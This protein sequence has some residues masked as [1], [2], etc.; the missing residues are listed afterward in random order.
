[1]N[2]TNTKTKPTTLDHYQ[3]IEICAAAIRDINT[4]TIAPI[5]KQIESSI[6]SLWP[7]MAN[8]TED[9]A[10]DWT[11]DILGCQNAE[12]VVK[13]IQRMSAIQRRKNVEHQIRSKK[14][15]IDS[16]QNEIAILQTEIQA[17]EKL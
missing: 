13:V 2:N 9:G 7:E 15:R 10:E 3:K 17:W 4:T 14:G 8:K 16:L 5:I 11:N 6:L 12:E 1:M